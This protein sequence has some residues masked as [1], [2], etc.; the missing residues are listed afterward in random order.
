MLDPRDPRARAPRI[1]KKRVILFSV[2][3]ALRRD[4]ANRFMPAPI[5][6]K[7]PGAQEWVTR[8]VRN[9]RA[10]AHRGRGRPQNSPGCSLPKKKLA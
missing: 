1:T 8:R 5:R 7:K 3:P 2:H 9:A 10:S 4:A 6:K